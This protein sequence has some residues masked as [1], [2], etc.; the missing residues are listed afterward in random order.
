MAGPLVVVTGLVGLGSAW[1]VFL[2]Y[3][4]GYCLLVPWLTSWRHGR[5][6]PVLAMAARPLAVGSGVGLAALVVPLAAWHWWPALWPSSAHLHAQ[7]AG[8]GVQP[9]MA[10]AAL[11][12][13]ALVNGPAEELCWRGWLRRR[14]HPGRRGRVM[15]ALAFTSYHG[16]TVRALAPSPTAMLVMLT[17]VLLAALW[18]DWSVA[19]W[20][21]LWPAILSHSGA[22]LGYVIVAHLILS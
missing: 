1:F 11:L 13:L 3:H 10:P 12:I 22:T 18:W 5:D 17:G 9:D 19:R 4:L 6:R 16:V 2:A 14:L 20:D 15:L 21:S 8:W 7:L